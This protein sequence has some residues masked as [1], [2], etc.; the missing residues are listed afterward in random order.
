MRGSAR[1]MFAATL[2]SIEIVI[3]VLTAMAAFGLRL[4]NPGQIALVA[5]VAAVL[6]VIAAATVRSGTGYAIGWVVQVLLVASGLFIPAMWVLGGVFLVLWAWALATGRRI[7]RERAERQRSEAE[8]AGD[9]ATL[10]V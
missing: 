10:D 8:I 1:R 4:A 5:A 6:A 7:D 2:L 3:I 9:A